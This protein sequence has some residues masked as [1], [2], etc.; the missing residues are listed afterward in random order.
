MPAVGD[1]AKTC[2]GSGCA[3]AD[4][5]EDFHYSDFA[6]TITRASALGTRAC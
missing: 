2:L 5:A 4:V 3:R 1:E 6:F